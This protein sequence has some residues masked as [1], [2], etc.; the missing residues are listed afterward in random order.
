MKKLLIVLLALTVIGIC[1]FA[2]D[3]MAAPA[4]APIGTFTAWNTGTMVAYNSVNSAAGTTGWI[5][6]WDTAAGIDQEWEFGYH[7]KDYGFYADLEFGMDNFGNNILSDPAAALLNSLVAS[8]VGNP[9]YTGATTAATSSGQGATISRFAT[10]YNFVPGLLSIQLGKP[11]QGRAPGALIEGSMGGFYMNSNF[12]AA[13][14]LLPISGFSAFVFA[15]VPAAGDLVSNL[16]NQLTFSGEYN[17]P[18]VFDASLMYSTINSEFTGGVTV[19]AIKPF[20]LVLGF[21]YTAAAAASTTAQYLYPDAPYAPY[22]LANGTTLV[23]NDPITPAA[24]VATTK[25]WVSGGGKVI[26]NLT[27]NLDFS[28]KGNAQ[29]TTAKAVGYVAAAPAIPANATSGQPAVAAV[30]QVDPALAV[31]ATNTSI[32]FEA[33]VE[34]A[35]GDMYAVGARLGYDDGN[36]VGLFGSNLGDIGDNGGVLVYPY[37][38]A[39]FANGSYVSFGIS[40]ESGAGVS[41]NNQSLLQ[42][43]ISYV[44]S[45]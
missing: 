14:S 45:F 23:Y 3:A 6:P 24:N 4:P 7:G 43:P 30:K 29:V 35:L 17:M 27:V 42:I 37:I 11:R 22:L 18:N 32:G 20:T 31:V 40:Y 9:P 41:V 28:Y 16:G 36:G 21:D 25:L 19:T 34:Y 13:L 44:W 2:D 12:G 1:A 26:D 33:Q 8:K 10:Y 39:N 5:N 15:G 38:K